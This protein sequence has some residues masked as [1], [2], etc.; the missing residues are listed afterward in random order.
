MENLSRRDFLKIGSALGIGFLN[1]DKLSSVKF[2]TASDKA[3]DDFPERIPGMR[4]CKKFFYPA[5]SMT[6][7]HIR[8]K[9]DFFNHF[10]PLDCLLNVDSSLE[11]KRDYARKVVGFYCDVDKNQRA[12]Y[13]VLDYLVDE[14]GLTSVYSEGV[15]KESEELF[16]S[17]LVPYHERHMRIVHSLGYFGGGFDD[18]MREKLNFISGA[19]VVMA[20]EGKLKI[21][22]CYRVSQL[23]DS[24]HLGN[25]EDRAS[26]EGKN[27]IEDLVLKT[28]SQDAGLLDVL[29]FDGA[30]SFE[31]N[32]N[33]WNLDNPDKKYSLIEVTPVNY[34][35]VR[36]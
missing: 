12:I 10:L 15:S 8:Q 30:Y 23:T 26:L 9:H 25:F 18:E 17:I 33:K 24:V 11:E 20:L 36:Y 3:F 5:S 22:G 27:F 16:N 35:P 28:I 4:N 21:R 31:D 34:S 1:C 2:L 14:M 32:I 19:D 7:V 6:L 29:V 13:S